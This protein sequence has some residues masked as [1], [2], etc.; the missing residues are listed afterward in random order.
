MTLDSM[1]EYVH[2]VDRDLRILLFNKSFRDL[3]TKLGLDPEAVGRTLPETFS[4]LPEDVYDQYRQ[5]FEGGEMLVTVET[6]EVEGQAFITEARKIPVYESGAVTRVVTVIQ[7]ITSRRQ[8]EDALREAHAELERRVQERTTALRD[9]T[10]QLQA[11][12]EERRQ[13]QAALVQ[14][15]KRLRAQYRG[16]PVPTFTF[17][18]VG[19]DF[20]LVDHNEAAEVLT[21][22]GV[23]GFVGRRVRGMFADRM[24]EIIDEMVACASEQRTVRVERDYPLAS[25][26]ETRRFEVTYVPVSGEL[27]MIHTED[28]T[29]RRRAEDMLKAFSRQTIQL[30]EEERR[31]VGRELH[32]GVNQML[33]AL[34]YR[35]E[36]IEEKLGPHDSA[37]RGEAAEARGLLDE[38]IQEVRRI[39]QNLRPSSLDDLG[40]KAAA[41][42]LCEAFAGRTGATVRMEADSLPDR[43]PEEIETTLYRILQEAL[44]NAERHAAATEVVLSLQQEDG[45][46]VLQ[47]RD[48]G[49]GF[50]VAAGEAVLRGVG[51][52]SMEERASLA[53]GSMAVRSGQGEGTE[54]TVR[55]PVGESA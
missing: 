39:S 34:R 27:V 23:A 33:S 26:G 49:T 6:T 20:E 55:V 8:A 13:T 7:D 28:I 46:A 21:Q 30:Q 15:E 43:L 47:V 50:G 22:G 41:R 19:D 36:G 48:N 35:I 31:R 25:T 17:R 3:N 12:V 52:A 5:V 44:M 32:D 9:L 40:L 38:A 54:L 51:L 1:A 2:V 45:V 16:I 4:F 10:G 14:S 29:E 11:E 42:G 18:R 37:P 24:P 53:G